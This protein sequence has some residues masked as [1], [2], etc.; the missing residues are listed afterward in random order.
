MPQ[1]RA[2]ECNHSATPCTLMPVKAKAE[3]VTPTSDFIVMVDIFRSS[4]SL[5]Q[6]S[7]ITEVVEVDKKISVIA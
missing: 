5:N 3:V 6:Y 4:E 7:A 1:N 2:H